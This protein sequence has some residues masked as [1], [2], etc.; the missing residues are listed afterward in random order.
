MVK[1]G[2]DGEVSEGKDLPAEVWKKSA[3]TDGATAPVRP[4][5]GPSMREG[6]TPGG[7]RRKSRKVRKSRKGRKG[8]KGRKTRK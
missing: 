3:P 1:R 4:D 7:R 8:S 5:L 2:G 6:A